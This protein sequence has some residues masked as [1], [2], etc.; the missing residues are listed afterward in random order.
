MYTEASTHYIAL[1]D[2]LFGI[3]FDSDQ[4]EI[5]NQTMYESQVSRL[6][7]ICMYNTYVCL[8]NEHGSQSGVHCFLSDPGSVS[9]LPDHISDTPGRVHTLLWKFTHTYIHTN[10]T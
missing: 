7:Y 1:S 10:C 6:S 3:H 9:N 5:F 8:L 4:M 2:G